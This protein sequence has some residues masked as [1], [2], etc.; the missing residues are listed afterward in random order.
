MWQLE[1]SAYLSQW[2]LSQ[3]ALTLCENVFLQCIR[4]SGFDVCKQ[5][6]HLECTPVKFLI[7]VLSLI[8]ELQIMQERVTGMGKKERTKLE[9]GL[10]ELVEHSSSAEM[11]TIIEKF[12]KLFTSM[13][14]GLVSFATSSCSVFWSGMVED[15]E[16]PCSIRGKLGGPSQRRLS[17]SATTAVL[18]AII[19]VKAVAYVS[20]WCVQFRS[21]GLLNFVFIFLWKFFWKIVSSPSFYSET[22]AEIW[23]AAYE[24][25]AHGLK[26]VVSAF[27]S[28]ALDLIMENYKPS[29]PNAEGNSILDS[30][31]LSFLQNINN[32]IA[33]E[34]LVRSRRAI[35]MNWKW[36]C[37]EYL[38]SIPSHAFENG[39]R[40]ENG[41][42]FFSDATLH[43]LFRDLVDSL[44][45][46]GEASVLPMLRSIRLVLELLDS[47]KMR[48]AVSSC[49]G[50]DSQMMWHLVRSSWILHVSCKKRRVAPIAALLSSVLHYSV[51][52]KE[53]MHVTD[54]APGPL[55]W[56]I[57][58]IVEEGTKSPRT[59]RLAALHLT[60]L[61]LL[62]PNTIKYYMK[63]LKLLTLHGSAAFDEDFEA[64]LAENFDARREVSL[65]A[66]SPDFELTE[67]F[68]NTEL[69]ARVS[70]AVLFDK[71]AELAVVVGSQNENENC[72]AALESG[73]MFLLEL[74][75]LVVNDKDLAKELYKKYSGVH[76]RKI[77][78]WQMISI[79]SQF[80]DE[81]ILLKVTRSLH[82]SL[83]RN[84]FPSVR[85]YLET[86]AINVY[87][88]FPSL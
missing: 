83:Y 43:W 10:V 26:A 27:S 16:L 7:L 32:L 44:D 88:K 22:A 84:N 58:K 63:E 53:W 56:F 76:R 62:N 87:F 51:F 13:L 79:L 14:E 60:G 19:S 42:C 4:T 57:E 17:S 36:I 11:S 80:V 45:N 50:M 77:R 37:L 28:L 31:V 85:Q 68:I 25:L 40:L 72:H 21:D 61:W 8:E 34:K 59:I 23:L 29:S 18:Q 73:K 47:G 30:L 66:K 6:N 48:S 81:N 38:L 1:S 52:N 33:V 49:D 2:I 35:L 39:V 67:A 9:L 69:Y 78:V 74:L 75:D 41:N 20:L 64:E 65:L 55:K 71:L 70:V 46:A 12:A 54:D 3:E 15:M 24:A 82:M 5:N 86:F